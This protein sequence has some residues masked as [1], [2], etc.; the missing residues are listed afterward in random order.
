MLGKSALRRINKRSRHKITLDDHTFA[1]RTAASMNKILEGCDFR[2]LE[3]VEEEEK[4]LLHDV[5]TETIKRADKAETKRRQQ[6]ERRNRDSVK[7]ALKK[8]ED[9]A[10]QAA[11]R[12][13]EEQH[14]AEQEAARQE[15]AE[16]KRIKIKRKLIEI[17]WQGCQGKFTGCNSNVFVD[18]DSLQFHITEDSG[19]KS[20]RLKHLKT[21]ADNL[22][23]APAHLGRCP[24]YAAPLQSFWCS[25]APIP[26]PPTWHP[27]HS[28]Y[29]DVEDSKI[30]RLLGLGTLD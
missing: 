6:R 11:Q 17:Q 16:R 9:A 3:Q 18:W 25:Q 14:A 7:N 15:A 2:D 20:K 19:V 22:D 1:S 30:R 28:G 12:E 26:R 21:L 8:E 29:N 10:L 23:L 5:D 4:H 27:L 24:T 13:A